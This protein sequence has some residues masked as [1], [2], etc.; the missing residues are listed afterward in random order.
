MKE[1]NEFLKDYISWIDRGALS[2]Y[3]YL[4]GVGLCSN[5]REYLNEVKLPGDERHPRRRHAMGELKDMFVK[6][7]LCGS[8]PFN[9]GW[10]DYD[11]EVTNNTC[12]KNEAR[13]KWVKDRLAEINQ[14]Q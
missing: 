12:Y 10:S 9:V 14:E 7:G 8:Y 1:I 3:I 4:R 5:L 6:D 13:I 11:N 2:D